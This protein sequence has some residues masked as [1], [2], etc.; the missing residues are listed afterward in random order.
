MSL[1][2]RLALAFVLLAV[3]ATALL[4]AWVR[5]SSR[6]GLEADFA[7][8]T[9]AATREVEAALGAEATLARD[10]LFPL[11]KNGTFFD[12]ALVDL[13]RARGDVGRL[14]PG[15]RLALRHHVPDEAAARRLDEL[16]LVTT[17][18]LLLASS[19]LTKMGSKDARLGEL[20]GGPDEGTPH[21]SP[22]AGE[23]A[24]EIHCA[25]SAGGHRLALVAHKRIAGI[26][27]R[28]GRAYGVSL[29]RKGEA[30]PAGS[31]GDVVRELASAGIPGL[32][33]VATVSRAPLDAAIARVDRA[34]LVSSA[35][36]AFVA[37]V[38]AILLSR[39]LSRPIAALAREAREVAG[40]DPRPVTAR[41]GG[42]EMHEL[43][44]AFNRAIDDLV[45]MRKRLAA[46]ERIAARREIARQVAHEI[47]NP[48]A[49]IRAAVETLRRL[50]DRNDEA[51]ESYFDEATRTVLEEVHRIAN[52][53]TEFT[54]FSRL[55]APS[56]APMDLAAVA[57]TIVAL[58]AADPEMVRTARR[59]DP[60]RVELSAEPIP[61]VRADKDQIIQVLT[62]LIQNGLDAASAVRPD[63]RVLVSIAPLGED[64]V[65]LVVRDNGPGVA[66]DSREK[67]F[68][69]Y[70]TTK[71]HG[72]GL[73]LAIVQRIVV[74]HGGEISYRAATKG[75]AVFE[76]V[77]PVAGPSE[78]PPDS[79]AAGLE[80]HGDA[81]AG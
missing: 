39:T 14:D 10:L 2:V 78:R 24:I 50:K 4:G 80:T 76:I 26:L 6:A 45:R 66:E 20:A 1:A 72:T 27:T 40:G 42:K 67:L 69:P 34:I 81:D 44:A 5:E 77:L 17:Q 13:E 52:I 29:S 32:A 71:A 16:H 60:P 62:N 59:N 22:E 64:R 3:A 73:G 11:C 9:D 31:D 46:T 12:K 30:L 48:L 18:G 8:R 47:K 57:K 75:G 63:P 56:P 15:A 55:P 19:D 41:G 61:E 36:A 70:F 28:V 35:V 49:P 74:E 7:A 33:V 37:L 43:A 21:M 79:D 23:A 51:F 38:V 54:K 53:V 65:R 68:Q 25:R 58:H